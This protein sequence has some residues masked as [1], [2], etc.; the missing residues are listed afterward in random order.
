M[1]N[2]SRILG[3]TMLWWIPVLIKQFKKVDN[4]LFCVFSR[5]GESLL[6]FLRFYMIKHISI[7]IRLGEQL[8]SNMK[9]LREECI[10][11]F[12][13]FVFKVGWSLSR[14]IQLI[15]SWH[16]K[17]RLEMGNVFFTFYFWRNYNLKDGYAQ[18]KIIYF[19]S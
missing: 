19:Q 11:V 5:R 1:K 17:L 9:D 4:C 6:K 7:G 2:I 10:F 16:V 3:K 13:I 14:D 15:L 18:L 12:I 8:C